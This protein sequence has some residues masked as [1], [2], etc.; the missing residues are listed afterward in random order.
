MNNYIRKT[1]RWFEERNTRER[2]LV[3]IAMWALLYA[4]FYFLFYR[5]T[6]KRVALL[7]TE[8]KGLNDQ[9]KAWEI[10]IETLKKIANSPLYKEWV[11]QKK[12]FQ[13]L[14][15]QYEV[16]LKSS[17]TQQLE[18]AVKKILHSQANITLLQIKN[19][20]ETSYNP[21]HLPSTNL[22]KIYQQKLLLVVSS[23][24]FDTINYLERL[25][26]MLPN[27]HWDT[28]NYQVDQY[29]L[30]KVEVEFSIFYAKNQ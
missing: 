27:I 8:I 3:F 18:E 4:F 15:G 13:N 5:T 6:D 17:P 2:I 7:Q 23:N 14:Q 24:Y 19:F 11:A 21:V 1:R 20:P 9:I 25:E 29:P 28:M 22:S 26:N 12:S 16:L 10:Q 30:A